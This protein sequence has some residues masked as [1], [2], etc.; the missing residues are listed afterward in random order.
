MRSHSHVVDSLEPLSIELS[1]RNRAQSVCQMR[2]C[3]EKIA[4]CFYLQIADNGGAMANDD[5]KSV[6]EVSYTVNHDFADQVR[7]HA[8]EP[9]KVMS[10]L[11]RK[12]EQA[13][14]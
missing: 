4:H 14:P 10:N 2:A 11:Y 5:L 8:I 12:K 9:F 3:T 1:F 7:F 13:V 6:D